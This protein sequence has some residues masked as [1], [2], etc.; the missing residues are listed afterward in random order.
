[1]AGER[2]SA[3]QSANL[4][5]SWLEE[6]SEDD[7]TYCSI[8]ESSDDEIQDVLVEDAAEADDS[9]SSSAEENDVLIN[10]A[11]STASAEYSGKSGR[12]WS[13]TPP[14]TSRTRGCNIFTVDNWGVLISPQNKVECFDSFFPPAMLS[15]ILK[16]TNQHAAAHYA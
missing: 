14:P 10:S 5:R 15:H 1:M 3:T 11:A 7:D 6:D 16:Y 8:A 4:I 9:S 2:Y 12:R 13:G